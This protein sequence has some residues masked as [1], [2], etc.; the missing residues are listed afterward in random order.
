MSISKSEDS[1]LVF[2]CVDG[3]FELVYEN[4][5]YQYKIGDTILIPAKMNNFKISGKS[6]LLEISIS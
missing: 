5:K 6:E 2:M 1:F 4:E 3:S